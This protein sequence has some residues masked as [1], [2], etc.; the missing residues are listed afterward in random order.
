ML[1]KKLNFVLLAPP[2]PFLSSLIEDVYLIEE[3]FAAVLV[4]IE[5]SES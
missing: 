5:E 4:L 2:L 1:Y 3:S